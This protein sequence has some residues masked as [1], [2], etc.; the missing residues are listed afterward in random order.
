MPVFSD[1]ELRR[2]IDISSHL[3]I[4]LE[5]QERHDEEFFSPGCL[6]YQ[7]FTFH[8][9]LYSFHSLLLQSEFLSSKK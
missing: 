5:I 1:R 7:I 6:S 2:E 9:G 8:M 3:G 4:K